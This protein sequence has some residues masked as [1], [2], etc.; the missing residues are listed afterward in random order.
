MALHALLFPFDWVAPR[1]TVYTSGT[2][3]LV[4]MHE[5]RLTPVVARSRRASPIPD[6]RSNA[7]LFGRLG[8]LLVPTCVAGRRVA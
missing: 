2:D 7:A 1:D 3:G 6:F 8:S 5:I 4:V